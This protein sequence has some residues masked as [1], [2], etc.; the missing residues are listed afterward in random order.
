MVDR[1]NFIKASVAGAVLPAAQ[2]TQNTLASTSAEQ[3]FPVLNIGTLAEVESQNVIEFSYPDSASPAIL[4]RLEEAATGG[5]GPNN[6]IV[7]YSRL[8]THKGCPVGYRPGRQL[9]I[10]PCHWSTFDPARAG[11]MVIGQASQSLPQVMLRLDEDV[12]QA[13][14]VTGLIYGRQTNII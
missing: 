2:L 8:C 5:I 4:I 6:S 3:V 11:T 10:C 7:A 12:I 1:R 14:G 9:L 13:Y